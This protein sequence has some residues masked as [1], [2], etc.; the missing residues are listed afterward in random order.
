MDRAIFVLVIALCGSPFASQAG[1]IYNLE[2]VDIIDGTIID[3]Q[4]RVG[5][6]AQSGSCNPEL[7]SDPNDCP[8]L[9]FVDLEGSMYGQSVS[10]HKIRALRQAAWS[11]GTDG[12]LGLE[13][14]E[15]SLIR[16]FYFDTPTG[17]EPTELEVNT[18]GGGTVYCD[19]ENVCPFPLGN[20]LRGLITWEVTRVSEPSS[21][22]LLALLLGVLRWEGRKRAGSVNGG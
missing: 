19:N 14:L 16:F 12:E 8:D 6:A 3:L 10:F 20:G 4:G 22:A 9:S 17:V 5:F 15:L 18:Y 13:N 1:Y 2:V 21:I 7:S 11:I